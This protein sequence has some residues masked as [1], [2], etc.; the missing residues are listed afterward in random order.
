MVS[1]ATLRDRL[2]T[3][4]NW[5]PTMQPHHAESN[6]SRQAARARSERGSAHPEVAPAPQ[7]P[8]DKDRG[9]VV[10]VGYNATPRARAAFEFAVRRAGAGGTVVAVYAVAVSRRNVGHPYYVRFLERERLEG[11]DILDD[12][13]PSEGPV[14][15][16]ELLDGHPAEVLARV[17]RNR[18]AD[19]IVVGS[20]GLG[21][22]LAMFGNAVARQLVAMADR[23]VLVVPAPA[24]PSA[25]GSRARTDA[26]SAR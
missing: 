8:C 18:D 3:I 17:A 10:V 5:R 16:T 11:R 1:P 15:E 21:R 6:R 13:S 26:A 20:R 9:S 2:P 24:P 22:T 14:V 4:L 25:V 23:P 12:L 7:Q 19:E